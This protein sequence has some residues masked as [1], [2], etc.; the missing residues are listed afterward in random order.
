MNQDDKDFLANLRVRARC[1]EEFNPTLLSLY[2]DLVAQAAREQQPQGKQNRN[3]P[4]Q[5]DV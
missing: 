5:A 2:Q 1:G 4:H 3:S